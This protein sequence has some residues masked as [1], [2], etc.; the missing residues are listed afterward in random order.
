MLSVLGV[1]RNDTDKHRVPVE[2]NQ[3]WHVVSMCAK[4]WLIES[5]CSCISVSQT[6]E[7]VGHIHQGPVLIV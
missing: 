5:V 7:A 2:A 3:K 1:R 4:Q 6:P